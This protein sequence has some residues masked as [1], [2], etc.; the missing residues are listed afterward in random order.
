VIALLRIL[1]LFVAFG[2][3]VPARSQP[4][5]LRA[6]GVASQCRSA[7][8]ER[9]ALAHGEQGETQANSA[10]EGGSRGA[11]TPEQADGAEPE[12]AVGRATLT[13]IGAGESKQR[14]QRERAQ[15]ALAHLRVNGSANAAGSRA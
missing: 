9:I 4:P 1:H 13:T 15:S 5:T 14:P 8:L 6:E 2:L 3:L 12:C 7:A 11:P 10:F